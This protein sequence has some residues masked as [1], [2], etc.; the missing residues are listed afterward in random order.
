MDS[1]D[2]GTGAAPMPLMDNVGL[3]IRESL[4][5]MVDRL[6]RHGL[7]DRIKV[8]ASGKL[9]TLAEAAWAYCA[10]ADFVVSA[11]GFMFALGC[12]QA[13]QCNRNTC[14][15]GITTHNK[16]LQRGLNPENKAIRVNQY[17]HQMSRE[18]DIIAHSC[19]VREPRRLRRHHCRIVTETGRSVPL[20]E[21]YPNVMPN[22]SRATTG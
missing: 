20:D 14:P 5:L 2:G 17:A 12:I 18:I 13:L 8:I 21:L 1:G 3:P 10:G 7:R 4:P 6:D 11:R 22:E 16:R 19:G 9:I 15:T